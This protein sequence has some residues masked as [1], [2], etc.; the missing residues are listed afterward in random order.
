M[1]KGGIVQPRDK[2]RHSVALFD[3]RVSSLYK[4]GAFIV[5]MYKIFTH[6]REAFGET[7]EK[8]D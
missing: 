5:H 4:D 1:P 7:A 3:A 6:Q 8:A 2:G